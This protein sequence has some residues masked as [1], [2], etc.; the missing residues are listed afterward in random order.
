MLGELRIE[1]WG[2]KCLCVD[3]FLWRIIWRLWKA[4]LVWK[5]SALRVDGCLVDIDALD[6]FAF[7]KRVSLEA[8]R[9]RCAVSLLCGLLLF[10]CLKVGC[11]LLFV[12]VVK[13]VVEMF[14][15]LKKKL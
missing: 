12:G 2:L 11:G 4:A 5:K 3:C 14:C 7:L 1:N 10:C 9:T 15:G 8:E 13:I 6:R